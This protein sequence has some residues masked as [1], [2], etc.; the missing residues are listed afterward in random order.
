MKVILF[1]PP[2]GYF[3]ERWSQ[4]STM[5]NLGILY[6]AACIEQEGIPVKVVPADVLGLSLEEL[7]K[8]ITDEKPD[9]VGITVTTENRFDAFELAKLSKRALPKAITVIG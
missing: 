9:V 5:P 3:A 8:I 2:G 6:I 7:E 1:V 4:G